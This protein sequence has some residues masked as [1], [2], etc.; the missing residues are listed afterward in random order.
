MTS[1]PGHELAEA[2]RR[3]LADPTGVPLDAAGCAAP[4]ARVLDATVAHLRREAAVGGYA[5]ETEARPTLAALRAALGALVDLPAEL[6]A[7]TANATTAFTTLLGAW[8]LRSGARVA[9]L[10]SEYGS[11]RMALEAVAVRRDW[12]I[13]DLVAD[14]VGRLDLDRLEN[15]LRHG[16]DLVCFPVVASHRGVVQP[17]AEAAAVA[18]AA[19]VPIILDVAQAAGHVPLGGVSADAY[20]GTARKWL[21]GPRGSGWFATTA[22]VA[23]VLVPEYPG[24]T[25]LGE[26]GVARLELG[27]A[28]VAAHVGLA[29][30]LDELAAA[31]PAAVAGRIAALGRAARARLDGLA[32]WR[33][34]EPLDEP[35]G[36]VTLAHP[37]E[38]PM[39]TARALLERGIVTS[40]IPVARAPRDLSA[41]RLRI[42][43]HA[44]CRLD[45]LDALEF[46]L[47][48]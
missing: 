21:R 27:E 43:L 6:A 32:G 25:G 44:Y 35:S 11:N 45:D 8:P 34:Q 23:D 3:E 2:W 5:A 20:V 12:T 16:L 31:G 10:P 37:D 38:D 28:A 19:S 33:V 41:P 36:I 48:R 13:V 46:S 29:V 4:S 1:L 39:A 14:P 9:T 47:R 7:V 24:L 17:A 30:A 40:A 18:H 42:S 26:P 22:A 15:E